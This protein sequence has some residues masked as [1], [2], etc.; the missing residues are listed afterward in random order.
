[1]IQLVV[2]HLHHDIGAGKVRKPIAEDVVRKEPPPDPTTL[3][4][5]PQRLSEGRL[6]EGARLV[7]EPIVNSRKR[8]A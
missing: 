8:S 3:K 5:K 7:A 6:G 2:E 1:M 4:V